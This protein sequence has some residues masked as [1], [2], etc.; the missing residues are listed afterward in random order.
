[1]ANHAG[2][3]GAGEDEAKGSAAVTCARK[4]IAWSNESPC[5]VAAAAG[6]GAVSVAN[7][8]AA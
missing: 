1:M 6:L 5:A 8:F 2:S 7:R 4:A 3:A